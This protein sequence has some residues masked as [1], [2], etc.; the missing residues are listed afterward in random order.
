MVYP[1]HALRQDLETAP[2]G[3][4]REHGGRLGCVRE[5]PHRVQVGDGMPDRQHAFDWDYVP[6]GRCRR[7]RPSDR[8]GHNASVKRRA[9]FPTAARYSRGHLSMPNQQLFPQT[10]YPGSGD[11]QT[12]P[13]SPFTTVVGWQGVSVSAIPPLN[14]Q[15]E[16]YSGTANEWTPTSITLLD[17]NSIQCNGVTIS[18]DYDFY[19][20][21]AD[22]STN[23]VHSAFPPNGAPV[24]CNGSP[25]A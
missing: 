16:G 19:C 12:T 22:V 20:N 1:L 24:Y 18:P 4:L 2:Q 15:V 23:Q 6:M 13:G 11:I 21:G 5:S 8:E 7:V 3:R 14:G 25:V 9:K 17:N 10:S